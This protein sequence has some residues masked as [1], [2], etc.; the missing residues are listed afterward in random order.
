VTFESKHTYTLLF[1]Q[2]SENPDMFL[3]RL[4]PPS[5]GTVF[6]SLIIM[7]KLRKMEIELDVRPSATPVL[8]VSSCDPL[9]AMVNAHVS[10]QPKKIKELAAVKFEELQEYI[11]VRREEAS[12]SSTTPK[13][14]PTYAF[15][16]LQYPSL[17]YLPAASS[18]LKQTEEAIPYL[19]QAL[20]DLASVHWIYAGLRAV[21]ATMWMEV[22]NKCNS[23]EYNK[24]LTV[25]DSYLFC[26][27]FSA[28]IGEKPRIQPRTLAEQTPDEM[29]QT[30]ALA[31]DLVSALYII[32]ETR[33]DETEKL[34]YNRQLFNLYQI[35]N[36]ITSNETPSRSH[37]GHRIAVRLFGSVSIRACVGDHPANENEKSIILSVRK[38]IPWTS[39]SDSAQTWNAMTR[40]RVHRRQWLNL[41][42]WMADSQGKDGKPVWAKLYTA[43][44]IS[45]SWNP[46]IASWNNHPRDKNSQE[47]RA[48][49]RPDSLD[50]SAVISVTLNVEQQIRFQVHTFLKRISGT[51]V[52]TDSKPG[53]HR[54]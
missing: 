3:I 28:E 36:L 54:G 41:A 2:D 43:K 40:F 47:N 29:L 45:E 38:T 31:A 37:Y 21:A 27:L 22:N 32:L 48:E 17:R 11:T 7:N 19:S 30:T 25:I 50:M 39:S 33:A 26:V 46:V 44:S 35:D 52:Q 23:T 13:F 51:T 34:K 18:A 49:A 9:K 15:L 12:L 6:E 42:K 1:A 16:R 20:K 53:R 14:H 10:K 4:T 8:L 24:A 5:E